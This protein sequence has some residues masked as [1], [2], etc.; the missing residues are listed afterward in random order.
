MT[1]PE[2]EWKRLKGLPRTTWTQDTE[3]F[4]RSCITEYRPPLG[5]EKITGQN[6]LASPC[7]THSG[8]EFAVDGDDIYDSEQLNIV[9]NDLA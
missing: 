8:M 2:A 4:E 7:R 6:C 3:R 1:K 5:F 9:Y